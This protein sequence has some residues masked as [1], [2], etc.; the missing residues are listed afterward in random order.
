M[1]ALGGHWHLLLVPR[2][3]GAVENKSERTGAWQPGAGS[4]H[5]QSRLGHVVLTRLRENVLLLAVVISEKRG[6]WVFPLQISCLFSTP[7]F[8][9]LHGQG[10]QG[11]DCH[12]LTL[13]L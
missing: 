6:V 9:L 5:C 12:G 8:K 4:G 13:C 7:T 3:A 10:L 11:P 1:W 2:G